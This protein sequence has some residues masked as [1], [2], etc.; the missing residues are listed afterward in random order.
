VTS[1]TAVNAKLKL[2]LQLIEQFAL[3]FPLIKA[4]T[5]NFAVPLSVY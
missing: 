1:I 2:Y 3:F 5:T 4:H